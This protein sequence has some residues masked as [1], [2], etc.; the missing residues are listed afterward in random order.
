MQANELLA[1]LIKAN[2]WRKAVNKPEYDLNDI[3]DRHRLA[4]MLE[5]ALDPKNLAGDGELRGRELQ[6]KTRRLSLA[7]K[8]LEWL[9]RHEAL[10]TLYKKA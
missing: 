3:D 10:H 8:Q 2:A 6:E 5:S 1:Y 4:D 7:Q 9:E